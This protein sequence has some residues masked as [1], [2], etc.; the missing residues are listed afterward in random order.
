MS[1]DILKDSVE[2]FYKWISKRANVPPILAMYKL[3][4]PVI[5]LIDVTTMSAIL[6]G[7]NFARNDLILN[8]PTK[9][10]VKLGNG[11]SKVL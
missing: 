3:L 1:G 9:L 5:P 11:L 8:F 2:K 10:D 7:A 6:S 4:K